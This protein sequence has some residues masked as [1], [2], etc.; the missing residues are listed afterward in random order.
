MTA[1]ELH[2][3][4]HELLRIQSELNNVARKLGDNLAPM[5]NVTELHPKK[6]DPPRVA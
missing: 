5:S 1:R 4:Y 2:D 6:P 3:I